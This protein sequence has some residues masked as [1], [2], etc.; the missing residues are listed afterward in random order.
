MVCLWYTFWRRE[1]ESLL[2]FGVITKETLLS[3]DDF[4]R[5]PE[6][7]VGPAQVLRD[8]CWV[9]SKMGEGGAGGTS[10]LVKVERRGSGLK[11]QAL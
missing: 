8:S 4:P 7:T 9:R 10:D 5:D 3:F 1:I 6:R 11:P 2:D